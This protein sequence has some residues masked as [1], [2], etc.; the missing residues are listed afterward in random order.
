MIGDAALRLFE[1]MAG[2][3][4]RPGAAPFRAA[5]QMPLERYRRRYVE[6]AGRF[7]AELRPPDLP[8]RVVY[9]FGGGDLISA[10]VAFPNAEEITTLS[11]EATGD[12]RPILS[13]EGAALEDALARFGGRLGGLMTGSNNLSQSMSAALRD[14][15]P[16]QLSS[17][18]LGLLVHR[19]VPV[20]IRFVALREDGTTAALTD[21]ELAAEE[22]AP[23]PRLKHD[24]ERPTWSAAFSHVE[25]HHAPADDPSAGMRVHRHLAVNLADPDLP[26]AALRYIARR[27]PFAA[28]TKASTFRLWHKSFGRIRQALLDGMVWMLSDSTGVPPAWARRAGFVQET[29]GRYEGSLLRAPRVHDR[30]FMAL[31]EESPYRPVPFRFGYVDR[32]KH[33][34]LL[35]TRRPTQPSGG[36]S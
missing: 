18:L 14:P 19:R 27:A 21:A 24:W 7:L 34:H 5:L 13:L 16:W 30:A 12:P 22:A 23:A 11:L 32:A 2:L 8:T 10:L 35:V 36:T 31:W 6:G 3:D 20:S 1:V 26:E 17:F 15:L 4:P 28:L 25:I 33:P 29:W 9:P